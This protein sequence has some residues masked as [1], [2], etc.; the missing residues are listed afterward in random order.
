MKIAEVAKLTVK[1]P[2]S[3]TNSEAGHS[4]LWAILNA[5]RGSMLKAM[6]S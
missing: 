1:N 4:I 3:A 2:I 5:Q 6:R